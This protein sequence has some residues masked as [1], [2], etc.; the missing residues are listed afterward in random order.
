MM[1]AD[2]WVKELAHVEQWVSRVMSG[3]KI[4]L[5]VAPYIRD[6]EIRKELGYRPSE[7]DMPYRLQEEFVA[8][9][10]ERIGP[11]LHEARIRL[12]AKAE[13]SIRAKQ[14]ELQESLDAISKAKGE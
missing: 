10:I 6:D 12:G 7:D 9:V 13:E 14:A 8:V 3:A 4:E 2:R 11:L 5:G 1:D